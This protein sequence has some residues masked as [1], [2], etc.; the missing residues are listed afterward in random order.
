MVQPARAA[1]RGRAGQGPGRME[2]WRLGME[3]YSS[4]LGSWE[5]A[6]W[7]REEDTVARAGNTSWGPAGTGHQDSA[8]PRLALLGRGQQ[9]L[10]FTRKE[11]KLTDHPWSH[12]E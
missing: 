5:W 8:L 6:G 2:G 12:R 7:G 11:A 3:R 9:H 4:R 10:H 1:S